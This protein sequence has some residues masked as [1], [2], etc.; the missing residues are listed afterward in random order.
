M[1]RQ[2]KGPRRPPQRQKR[3]SLTPLPLTYS[4]GKQRDTDALTLQ[5]YY[6]RINSGDEG[7]GPKPIPDGYPQKTTYKMK[8]NETIQSSL[9]GAADEHVGLRID[10]KIPR[11]MKL[12]QKAY[13]AFWYLMAYY[14]QDPAEGF[15][16]A[17]QGDDQTSHILIELDASINP[18]TIICI[19]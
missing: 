10:R 13:Q 14:R 17:R 1:E 5:D 2:F 6:Q 11:K 18:N 12:G 19:H 16:Y 9:W 4:S 15:T 8:P 7:T 3:N